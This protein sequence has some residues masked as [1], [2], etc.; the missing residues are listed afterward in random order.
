MAFLTTLSSSA[1]TP[2]AS[3][4][5]SS[6][7]FSRTKGSLKNVRQK[8]NRRPLFDVY[9][10]FKALD[11]NESGFITLDEFKELL[12]D[13]GIY[14]SSN[15]LLNLMKRF[16]KNQDGKVSYSEFVNEITPK[17]PTKLY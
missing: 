16:D 12:L 13:H 9:D 14:T 15:E 10:A 6:T 1:T 4:R 3:S 2:D 7:C 5:N 8:L 17:S 11:K